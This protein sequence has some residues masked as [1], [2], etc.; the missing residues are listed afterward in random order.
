MKCNCPKSALTSFIENWIPHCVPFYRLNSYDMHL[1][2]ISTTVCPVSYWIIVIETI[3]CV[4]V[5]VTCTEGP[6]GDCMTPMICFHFISYLFLLCHDDVN[7]QSTPTINV[8]R[9]FPYFFL[10]GQ[11]LLN[12]FM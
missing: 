8:K 1:M 9:M 10:N 5:F 2:A 12:D 6:T 4:C 7:H 11:P 3:N